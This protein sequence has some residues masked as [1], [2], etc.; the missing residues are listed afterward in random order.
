MRVRTRNRVRLALALL[1]LPFAIV[2]VLVILVGFV[3]A[4]PFV[5]ALG[6]KYILNWRGR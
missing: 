2:G 3:L 1:A 5:K 4:Y 6:L